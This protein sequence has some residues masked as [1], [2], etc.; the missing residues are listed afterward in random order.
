MWG[1]I[2]VGAAI[3]TILIN[4]VRRRRPLRRKHRRGNSGSKFLGLGHPCPGG[5]DDA[6]E[7]EEAGEGKRPKSKW[8]MWFRRVSQTVRRGNTISERRGQ[9]HASLPLSSSGGWSSQ[10]SS[11]R[12]VSGFSTQTHTPPSYPRSFSMADMSA[13][14]SAAATPPLPP[15]GTARSNRPSPRPRQNSGNSPY[16]APTTSGGWN[17]PPMT[18]LATTSPS[19]NTASLPGYDSSTDDERP[20]SVLTPSAGPGHEQ[21]LSRQ[22]SRVNLSDMG[23]A[24]RSRNNTP[25]IG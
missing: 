13:S 6:Y 25:H 8:A 18:L 12:S 16:L 10:P 15:K 3:I 11:P 24:Q 17:D 20:R 5:P 9:R 4:A 14:A 1:Y 7:Y 2:F 19:L 22:S 21:A 23:L